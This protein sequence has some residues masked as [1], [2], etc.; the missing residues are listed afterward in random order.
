MAVWINNPT[1]IK[2]WSISNSLFKNYNT[3][4]A[5]FYTALAVGGASPLIEAP[6]YNTQITGEMDSTVWSF[7]PSSQTN[8]LSEAR[9][10]A[11]NLQAIY[12]DTRGMWSL[13]ETTGTTLSDFSWKNHSLTS[14]IAMQSLDGQNMRKG[15]MPFPI[16]NGTDEGYE[17]AD[18]ADYTFNGTA[19]QSFSLVVVVE[20]TATDA[21][22]MIA[23]RD[24]GTAEYMLRTIAGNKLEFQLYDSALAENL[25]RRTT[26]A[27]SKNT[28]YVI[29]A[30][31]DGSGT[32]AGEKIYI[33]GVRVDDT[34]NSSGAYD[35]MRDNAVKVT[36]G[37][38]YSA[39]VYSSGWVGRLGMPAVVAKELSGVDVWDVTQRLKAMMGI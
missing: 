37:F 38:Q 39:A 16:L 7:A 22:T 36:V 13:Y 15:Q 21:M 27:L 20:P 30:T 19:D 18:N 29:V 11:A 8:V 9:T 28:T 17:A 6:I 12:G 10:T 14:L 5:D 31:Y 4:I 32:E 25:G 3:D 34:S 1:A 35:H 24:G 2:K 33:N 26:A 23:K